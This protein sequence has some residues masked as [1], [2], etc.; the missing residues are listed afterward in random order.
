MNHQEQ[1]SRHWLRLPIL[2]LVAVMAVALLAATALADSTADDSTAVPAA[3]TPPPAAILI[4]ANSNGKICQDDNQV[5]ASAT[6]DDDDDGDNECAL[7]YDNED[8]LN[9]DP[10]TDIWSVFWDGTDLGLG[11][12]NI[13]DF[14]YDP[15][16]EK[17]YFT[18]NKTFNIPNPNGAPNPLRVDDADIVVYDF[19]SGSFSIFATGAFF[20]INKGSEDID[21]LGMLPNGHLLISTIGSVQAN[22]A[23]GNDEDVLDCDPNTGQCVLHMDNSDIALTSGG[24]DTLALWVDPAAPHDH[25]LAFKSNWKAQGS[26]NTLSGQKGDVLGCTPIGAL[27]ANTDCALYL[28]FNGRANSFRGSIDGLWVSYTPIVV[29]AVQSAATSAASPED[30]LDAADFDEAVSENDSEV[31]AY[32]FID[33]ARQIFLPALYSR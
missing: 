9:Y 24:E 18:I 11:P 32:D 27:G 33:V 5:A 2:L 23:S 28:F 16:A 7:R 17:L 25:L 31:D 12:V 13:E 3:P 15:A 29:S 14:E 21:A 4:G 20:G 30:T 10:N 1:S 26:L 19:G 6:D 8:I 22:G